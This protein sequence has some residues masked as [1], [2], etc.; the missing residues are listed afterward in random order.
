V[1]DPSFLDIPIII[2]NDMPVGCMV[3]MS[4][5]GQ[6]VIPVVNLDI[7]VCGTLKPGPPQIEYG[8][9]DVTGNITAYFEDKELYAKFVSGMG[10]VARH[11]M[12]AIVKLGDQ[13]ARSGGLNRSGRTQWRKDRKRL[14]ANVRRADARAWR[15]ANGLAA[16]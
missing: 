6:Q 15:E 5:N 9:R 2:E 1:G 16:F 4:A 7:E 14:M 11:A 12:E 8:V 13:L 10:S 3:V